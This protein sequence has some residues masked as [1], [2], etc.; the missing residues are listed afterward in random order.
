MPHRDHAHFRMNR[1]TLKEVFECLLPAEVSTFVRHG[2]AKLEPSWL[3]A[4]TVTC[5]GWTPLGTLNDRV[6]MACSVV[7][8]LWNVQTTVTRQGLL[9]V[10]AGN[11]EALVEMVIDQLAATLSQLKGSWSRGGK[12]NVAVDGS[13]LKA[14]RTEANQRRFAAAAHKQVKTRSKTRKRPGQPYK[15]KADASKA[16]TVQ[17]LMTVFWHLNTGLPLRWKLTGSTGSER[18]SVQDM[19]DQLPANTRLIGDAEYVGYPLWSA[20]IQSR[21]S[22]LFRVGSNITLLK[23]LGR[24]RRDA[25]IRLLLAGVG[26]ETGAAAPGAASASDSQWPQDALPRDE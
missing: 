25:G 3:A 8:S 13:K 16:S 11:G 10:L 4:V 23:N 21:K 26:D 12:V 20:I 17:V 15:T 14:P 9:K 1:E 18:R 7:G 6:A 5:W 24:Y 2:N 22:F 19:L